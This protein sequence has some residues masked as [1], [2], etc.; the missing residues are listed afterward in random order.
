MHVRA[1]APLCS[2][3]PQAEGTI[4]LISPS[5]NEQPAANDIEATIAVLPPGQDVAVVQIFSAEAQIGNDKIPLWLSLP[6]Q[7]SG[8]SPVPG[9]RK[10]E[11]AWSFRI[12]GAPPHALVSV[13]AAHYEYGTT[14]D[15]PSNPFSLSTGT[16]TDNPANTCRL[17]MKGR[18]GTFMTR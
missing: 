16:P 1:A 2:P 13:F 3:A 10:Y 4:R 14:T 18:I 9:L 17:L 12:F 7:L 15:N 8:T 11:G 6:K 5:V